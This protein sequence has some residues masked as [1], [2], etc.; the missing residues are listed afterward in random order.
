MTWHGRVVGGVVVL[1]R[2]HSL[3]EGAEVRVEL[4][5]QFMERHAREEPTPLFQAGERA[6]PT[7][8]PDLSIN[9]DHYLYGLP[10]VT[11]A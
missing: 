1:D 11:G 8:I 5:P 9:H 6:K 2:G 7:G 3:P 4:M 10:K